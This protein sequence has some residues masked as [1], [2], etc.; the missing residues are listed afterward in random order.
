MKNFFLFLVKFKF[1]TSHLEFKIDFTKINPNDS[2]AFQEHE[3]V[4]I[5]ENSWGPGSRK[6]KPKWVDFADIEKQTT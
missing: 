4:A 3:K 1:F 5:V 6:P 2:L